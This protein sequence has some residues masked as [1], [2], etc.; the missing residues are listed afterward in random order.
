M[1]DHARFYLGQIVHHRKFDYRGV[2]ID[3]DADFKGS[4]EWYDEVAQSRP[5]K[6]KPWYHVLVD[7]SDQVSYV[8]ERNLEV[9]DSLLPVE[10]PHIDDVFV[11]FADGVYSPRERFN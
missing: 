4:E 10:H 9:D 5:P 8:A 7:H 6:N 1:T 3:V 11:S 2:I